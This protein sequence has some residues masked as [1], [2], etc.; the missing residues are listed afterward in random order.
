MAPQFGASLTV[1]N[2]APKVIN[3]APRVINYAP[4]EH[5]SLLGPF[6]TYEENEVLQIVVL[7]PYSQHLLFSITYERSQ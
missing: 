3:C 5:T 7:G 6:I 2:Y 1:I 4:K